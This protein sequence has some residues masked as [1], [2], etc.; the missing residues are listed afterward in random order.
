MPNDHC[1][2]HEPNTEKIIENRVQIKEL[3]KNEDKLFKFLRE[4]TD[5]ISDLRVNIER[6][7]GVIKGLIS[8]EGRKT[9]R[10]I[11]GIKL[12]LIVKVIALLGSG[13]GIGE[14]IDRFL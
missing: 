2:N 7:L 9:D 3:K 11:Y 12:K 6:E 8:N 10:E 5:S 1:P 4:V 13:V 14:L